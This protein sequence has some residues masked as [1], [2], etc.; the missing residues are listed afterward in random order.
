VAN[1]VIEREHDPDNRAGHLGRWRW[2]Q[3]SHGTLASLAR[4]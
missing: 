3:E 4:D 2:A 1:G